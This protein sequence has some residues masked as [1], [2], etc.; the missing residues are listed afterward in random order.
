M[1][2]GLSGPLRESADGAASIDIEAGTIRQLLERLIA[3]YP[4]M[5][6]HM[7]QGIAVSIDGTL[8]RDNWEV[9]IP[10]DAEVYLVPRIVG[11]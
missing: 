3:R 1:Q 8:Y 2:V 11:G 10:A 5:E 7:D 9:E 4:R 6:I